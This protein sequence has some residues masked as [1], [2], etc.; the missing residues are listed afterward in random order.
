MGQHPRIFI[1][2]LIEARL[3]QADLMILGGL[4]EGVWPA[5]PAPDPWLAPRIRAELGLPSLERRIGLAA[6]DFACALGA[7]RCW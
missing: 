4:N 3:Q 5:A 6:H 2:G 7:R 1:W